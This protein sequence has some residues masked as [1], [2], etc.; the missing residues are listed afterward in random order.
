MDDPFYSHVASLALAA[1]QKDSGDRT[2]QIPSELTSTETLFPQDRGFKSS[3]RQSPYGKP[4]L[5]RMQEG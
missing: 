3:N 2:T 5:S 1:L 4:T